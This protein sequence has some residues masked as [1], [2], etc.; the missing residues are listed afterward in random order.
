MQYVGAVNMIEFTEKFGG[1]EDF[2]I[3]KFVEYF[4]ITREAFE[5]IIYEYA[6]NSETELLFTMPYPL[7]CVYGDKTAQALGFAVR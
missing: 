2:N 5:D 3:V 6:F 4:N 7:D 1:T